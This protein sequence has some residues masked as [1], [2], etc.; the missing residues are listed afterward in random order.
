FEDQVS[1]PA[2]PVPELTEQAEPT[3]Q[4]FAAFAPQR[5]PEFV[6]E[7]AAVV[8]E[9]LPAR[10][11]EPELDGEPQPSR[12][13]EPF[14]VID[15]GAMAGSIDTPAGDIETSLG[16]E[17]DWDGRSER[18]QPTTAEQVVPW[19]IGVI[20]LLVGMVIL[21]VALIFTSDNGLLAGLA[22]PSGGPN[23]SAGAG[24]GP[25]PDLADTPR[26]TAS[27]SPAT[28]KPSSTPPPLPT[29]G[30]LDMIYL[31]RSAALAHIYLLRHDFTADVAPVVLARDPAQ[32]VEHLSWS[33]DGTHG[34]AIIAGR[35]ITIEGSKPKRAL[36]DG[37]VASTF[38]PD[39]KSIYALRIVIGNGTDRA[40]VLK[41]TYATGAA[42]RL[43]EWTYPRPVLGT[44]SA[45]KE[46]QFADEGGPERLYWMSD[47]TLR[48]WMLGAPTYRVT[49][50]GRTTKLPAATL[51]VLWSGEGI[52]RIQMTE[53]GETT[54]ISL[55]SADGKELAK[56]TVKGLISHLRWS[57]DDSQVVFTLGRSVGGGVQQDLFLWNLS[58]D[59]P[60]MQLTNTGAAFG[61]EWLGT[62]Q[63]WRP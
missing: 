23:D 35:L 31:G 5:E 58:A 4:A 48:I 36:A 27:S 61:A 2:E 9:S 32:D 8:A 20:L 62:A 34:A 44:E 60:P 33:A 46:A 22:S 26:G 17:D 53:S 39:G 55:R 38:A 1:A 21:L 45:V 29:F 15:G 19:L 14:E 43:T 7:S 25:S 51:P 16:A 24:V 30:P 41:I 57:P 47:G 28:S 63:A 40:E 54:T 56:T 12:P 59:K 49:P 6:P 13:Y 18:R 52:K 11:P 3:E 37:I 42:A 10:E 50:T